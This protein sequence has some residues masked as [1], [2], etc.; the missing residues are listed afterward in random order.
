MFFREPEVE[1]SKPGP[2]NGSM[3]AS[4]TLSAIGVLAIGLLPAAFWSAAQS[5]WGNLFG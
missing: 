1:F 5:A 3:A 4:L 2:I